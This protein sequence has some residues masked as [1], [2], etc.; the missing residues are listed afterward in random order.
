MVI[1]AFPWLRYVT[2][3]LLLS[4]PFRTCRFSL[5]QIIKGFSFSPIQEAV[6][7]GGGGFRPALRRGHRLQAYSESGWKTER[8]TVPFHSSWIHRTRWWRW[9][10]RLL[11]L[12]RTVPFWR[13]R[14]AA[15]PS[16]TPLRNWEVSNALYLTAYLHVKSRDRLSKFRRILMLI[17]NYQS[18]PH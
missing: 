6:R 9:W 4:A 16:E 15:S 7:R 10:G 1:Q 14:G 2:G 12:L 17:K 11:L 13:C 8:R 5:F 18:K 3:G